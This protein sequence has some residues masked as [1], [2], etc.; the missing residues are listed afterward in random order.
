MNK[1]F[2][3]KPVFKDYLWGGQKLISKLHKDTKINPCAESWELS[4]HKDGLSFCDEG[5]Y[6]GKTLKQILI[7]HPD[8][9]GRYANENGDL[10]ILIKFIDALSDLS[11]QVHPSDEYALKNEGELGKTEVW[12]IL[13]SDNGHL[14]VGF[15][16]DT[17][18]EEVKKAIEDNTICDYINYFNVKKD[19][20]YPIESGTVH[21][22]G[23]GTMLVEIQENSNLTYRLYDYDR[24][25]KDGKKRPLHVDKALK[26]LD[27]S[28]YEKV[29]QEELNYQCKYFSL[30]KVKDNC[31]L[32]T[33]EDHFMTLICI[34]GDCL[35]K[36]S[37]EQLNI[38][39]GDT[40]F[41][42]SCC[43]IEIIGKETLLKV[44]V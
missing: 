3:V 13:E 18:S 33:D 24:V 1:A 35:I 32:D 17:N 10:P 37:N 31:V 42:P 12:Y 14:A 34:D 41:V 6:K 11:I 4:T 22:I 30:N 19:E 15:K 25:G 36:T 7:E 5:E 8:Y 26:V 28:K 16:N 38:K 20:F 39:L 43:H 21:A 27:Y 2:K 23:G 9:L 40:V 29:N 44:E